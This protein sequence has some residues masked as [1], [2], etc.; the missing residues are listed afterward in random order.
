MVVYILYGKVEQ[1]EGIRSLRI[2]P[3]SSGNGSICLSVRHPTQ[4]QVVR[5]RVI[6]DTTD[7][8]EPEVPAH[9]KHRHQ[10]PYHLSANWNKHDAALQG[11]DARGTL[12]VLFP[13]KKSEYDGDDDE[14]EE[15]DK[16]QSKHHKGK[17]KHHHDT[18][19]L[20]AEMK[21]AMASVREITPADVGTFVPLLAMDC[22]NLE[23]YAFHSSGN[24][25]LIVVT[26]HGGRT[27]DTV[28][29]SSTGDWSDFDM[30]SGSISITR[31]ES[32]FE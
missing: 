18:N 8:Q 7:L 17:K 19:A 14:Q 11:D 26:E 16:K 20:T 21:K 15:G 25:E 12:R 29:L 9:E 22:H 2:D 4:V 10:A 5:E 24:G 32:K 23:P 28:D 1:M 30:G 31:F 13:E 6:V 3:Q 27:I